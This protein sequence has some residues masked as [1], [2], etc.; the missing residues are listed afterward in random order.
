MEK[1]ILTN[2]FCGVF[3]CAIILFVAQAFAAWDGTSME[4]P[5]IQ[6]IEGKNFYLINNEAELAWFA[7]ETNKNPGARLNINAKLNADLDMGHKLWTPMAAGKGDVAFE[8]IID[9]DGHVISNLYINSEE[10]AQIKPVYAQNLGFVGVLGNGSVKNI[11]FENV[12]IV[13]STSA[14]TILSN[15]ANQISVGAVVGWLADKNPGGVVS[16]CYVS[17]SI[18]A[19]GNGQ[20]I[21]GIVGNGKNGTIEHC[22][23]AV[24]IQAEGNDAFVGGIIGI[25]KATLSV[26][27][28]VYNGEGLINTGNGA[29]GAVVGNHLSGALTTSNNYYD[30]DLKLEGVGKGSETKNTNH[31]V[32]LVNAD[33]IACALNGGE[34]LDGYCTVASPWSVG[35][36]N[37]ALNGYGAETISILTVKET[38]YGAVT[39]TEYPDKTVAKIDGNYTGPDTVRIENDIKVDE[40]VFN[41]N[42][43]VGKMST[44]MLPFSIDTSKVK[45]GKFYRFKRVDV[46]DG[47]RKVILGSVKTQQIG[48]NT[49]YLVMPEASEITFEGKATF[50]TETDPSET[51]VNNG[52]EFRGVYAHKIFGDETVEDDYYGFAGQEREGA[53]VGQFVKLSKGA[54][55]PALRAYLMYHQN[56]ALAKSAGE[57]LGSASWDVSYEIDVVI[58]D[59][60]D[61]VVETGKLNTLTGEV[62]MDRWFDLNGRKLNTKPTTRGTYYHNGKRVIV[63]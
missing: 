12:D 36:D 31:K 60:N 11:V 62:R 55:A 30:E 41:R 39:I 47:L 33:D 21:G 1:N 27:S 4:E 23:S 19:T 28:C 16:A 25:T 49:P 14:G 38:K 44:I 6:E 5:E 37:L 54:N 58:V 46:V 53:K 2:R 10:I 50:N 9:G 59:E 13:T 29:T 51:L 24:T 3:V 34:M 22:L 26:K 40:V 56:S 52:W 35:K 20:G 48:A 7:N 18:S 32:E 8:G 42:F 61:N 63:K 43:E 15:T 45:G 17:G 57:S